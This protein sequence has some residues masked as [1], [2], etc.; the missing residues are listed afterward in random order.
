MALKIDIG[1]WIKIE[2]TTINAATDQCNQIGLI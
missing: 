1:F 2:E